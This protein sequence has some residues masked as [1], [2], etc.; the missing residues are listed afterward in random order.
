MTSIK[1]NVVLNTTPIPDF[2]YHNGHKVT[3]P[4]TITS[5]FFFQNVIT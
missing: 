5:H 1:K 4:V 2:H 3:T